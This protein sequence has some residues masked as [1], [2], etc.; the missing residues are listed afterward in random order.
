VSVPI[1]VYVPVVLTML[2]THLFTVWYAMRQIR[3]LQAGLV[4]RDVLV[5]RPVHDTA[6]I[7]ANGVM[8]LTIKDYVGRIRIW[9]RY[10]AQLRLEF[11]DA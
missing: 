6:A 8:V 2:G 5:N 4:A 7:C 3:A 9:S 10:H 11:E 1:Y